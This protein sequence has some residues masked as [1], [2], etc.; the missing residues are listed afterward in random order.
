MRRLLLLLLLLVGCVQPADRAAPQE[1]GLHTGNGTV[2]QSP[3]HGPELC[4]DVAESLPPQCTGIPL[5]GW[6][7]AAADGEQSVN[8][9]TWGDYSVVGR[10]D[11]TTLTVTEPPSRWT[12]SPGGRDTIRAGCDDPTTGGQGGIAQ[13]DLERTI[14][15]ARAEVD[16]A[17]AWIDRSVLTLAFTGAL[18]RHEQRARETW[19]G[20]LCVVRHERSLRELKRIQAEVFNRT[21]AELGLEVRSGGVMEVENALRLGVF[22]ITD[23]QQRALD[24]RYGKGVVVVE[25]GLREQG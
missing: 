3:A 25:P 10:W 2:L 7:W 8:G 13:E 9:T 12:P 19:S 22:A 1:P 20:P 4:F 17:G 14:G 15:R 21:G 5:A 11:G 6:D 18:D 16:H 24:E 23:E